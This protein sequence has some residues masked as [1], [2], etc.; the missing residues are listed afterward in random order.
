MEVVG[1]FPALGRR[2]A[3]SCAAACLALVIPAPLSG[4]APPVVSPVHAPAAP[5]GDYRI[6]HWTIAQG[7]PQNSVNDIVR[8]PNGELWLATFGG[9]ARFDGERFHVK[10]MATDPELPTHRMVSLAVAGPDALWYL[11]QQGHLG[12]V[13]R[14]VA[15]TIAPAAMAAVDALQLQVDRAGQLYFKSADGSGWQTDGTRPWQRIKGYEGAL[16]SL[17]VPEDGTT[18]AVW[19]TRLVHLTT[20][21]RGR[22]GQVPDAGVAG[23]RREGGGLWL[24][25]GHDI[26][27]FVDDRLTALD[28][29]PPIDQRVMSVQQADDTGALWVA[30]GSE[31]SRLDVQP[32]GSWRRRPLPLG[33]DAQV[34]VRVLRVDEDG[35]LWVG[36]D[37]RGLFRVNRLP[38]RLAGRDAALRQAAGLAPDGR[39]GAF[40]VS[41]CRGLFH[42]DAS[43]VVRPVPLVHTANEAYTAG[44]GCGTALAPGPASSV[45]VRAGPHVFTVDA[46]SLEVRR[47]RVTVPFDEGPI[48]P[49]ADGRLWVVSRQGTVH[50]LAG[51]GRVLREWSLPSPLVS[52]SL[53][54]D[55][56]VWLGGDGQVF[57]VRMDAES[58]D[59]LG[60]NEGM[61]RGVVRDVLVERDGTAWIGTYGGG[62]GRLRGGRVTRLSVAHGLPD[63][64]V[65][66]ILDDGRGRLWISTNRGV[67]V[68]EKDRL[69]RVVDGRAR[70][71]DSV[72]FGLE[73]GVGEANYGNPAGFVD[74]RG[75]MW[76]GTIE[77]AVRLDSA[78][79]P[80]NTT[81]PAVNIDS[82]WADGRRLPSAPVVE[83][84]ASAGRVRVELAAASLRYP[85][86][87]RF[88]FRVEGVD[89][90]WVD[91][92]PDRRI[93]WVPPGP[94]RYRIG[95]RARN[96]DGIWSVTPTV[97]EF[98]V[99]PAWW[100][101][102][103]VRLGA[104][105]GLALAAFAA[106]RWR[107]RTIERRHRG[108]LARVEELRAA[109]EQMGK[110]REQLHHVSRVALVGELA[111]SLAHEVR[112]PIGAM[113]NN[114]EAGRRHLSKYLQRPEAIEA[115]FTD[116]VSDGL[117]AS[118]IVRGM[119][120]FLRPHQATTT[121]L[122]LS[123]L[124]R[125]MLPLVRRELRDQRIE[126]DLALQDGLPTVDGVRVQ[127]GQVFV[128]FVMNACESLAG[129]DGPRRMTIATSAGDGR[130]E[131]AVCDSGPGPASDVE[132]R[133]FEAFVTTKP[134]GLGMGLAIARSIAEAHGGHV[135]AERPAQGGFRVV[136]SLPAAVAA[137]PA[138]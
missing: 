43:D 20:G 19:G 42:V 29:R 102:P 41:G 107:D 131:L 115:I 13:E 98:D 32:D 44:G 66:R 49:G 33:L 3:A 22:A 122:E 65:S 75:V 73:R 61:P 123:D 83:V 114:A 18:W 50:L 59:R 51:D 34:L 12:R 112:Q 80:F 87:T 86:Q 81:P 37:G 119:R 8:L 14:G 94:G 35:S 137:A 96:E 90:D 103:A 97:V 15:S 138:R 109:D 92:G 64:S 21:R 67:V 135:T 85:E 48:V 36:T 9:L 24:A 116:I 82:V 79:F 55:G 113:V 129:V 57:R 91:V 25:V 120:G 62:I 58:V 56:A 118:E 39:G 124:V 11:T 76:F 99:Q 52:A 121:Q 63:N 70:T 101:R 28:V 1:L 78:A 95:F 108:Q 110:L 5:L 7:L 100:Q 77:G 68:F 125:E 128:N 93:S 133:M 27:R 89:P 111:A 117:R 4:Q 106:F 17:A 130:V 45:W 47:L 46:T 134:D 105:L 53:G 104:V 127:L 10:D 69:D 74:P 126:V 2:L 72:V 6:V 60:A 71:A 31:V 84:P 136:L 23:F 38:A 88:G 26:L 30:A 16:Q 132:G 40:I 54:D